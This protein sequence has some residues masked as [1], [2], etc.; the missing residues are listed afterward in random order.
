MHAHARLLRHDRQLLNRRRTPDVRRHHNRVAALFRQPLRQLTGGRGLARTL[1]AEHQ[2]HARPVRALLQPALGIAEQREQLITNNLDDLL[3]RGQAL[4]DR[5]IH[6]PIAHAIDK[7]LDD[8]EIDVSFE[9]RQPDLPEGVLDGRLRQTCFS[10]EGLEDV[11]EAMAERVEHQGRSVSLPRL[12]RGAQTLILL[13]L[14]K[15]GQTDSRRCPSFS[16]FT[17]K[18]LRVVAEAGISSGSVS[19]TDRP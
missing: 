7:C 18:Y 9:Q 5:L 19:D 16:F 6:R 10:L 11:L 3:A 2:D 8:L 12:R 17:F 15:I 4:E 1:Q 13:E 14:Q